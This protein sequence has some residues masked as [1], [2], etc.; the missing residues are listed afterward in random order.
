MKPKLQGLFESLSSVLALTCGLLTPLTSFAANRTWTGGGGADNNWMTAAN[1]QG[2][3]APSPG[4]SLIF[5]GVSMA[6]NSTNRNNFPDGTPF[7]SITINTASGQDFS[8]GG[9]RVVLSNG[10]AESAAGIGIM[11]LAGNV[12][13]NITLGANGPFTAS[14]ALNLRNLIDTHGYQLIVNGTGNTTFSG[15]LINSTLD[16]PD[17]SLVKTNTGTLTFSSAATIPPTNYFDV[18]LGQGTFLMGGLA[19][20]AY[21]QVGEG[22][23]VLDGAARL[24]EL[25]GTLEGSANVSGTGFASELYLYQGGFDTCTPGD[26][27]APGILQCASFVC[28]QSFFAAGAL[29]IKVNGTTPGTGYSQLLVYSNYTL[30][31]VEFGSSESLAVQWDYTPQIGDSFR[32]LDKASDIPYSITTNSFFEGLPPNCI[33]DLTNGS[34]VAVIYDTNGVTLSTVRTSPQVPFPYGKALRVHRADMEQPIGLSLTT[35][36][37]ARRQP[38]E[39]QWCSLH[40]S[41]LPTTAFWT[42]FPFRQ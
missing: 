3:V 13:F 5:N 21:V 33:D 9:N 8:L 40:I 4:D 11:A 42:Q 1:W 22:T 10:I 18:N 34:S 35:G 23:F 39:A 7:G 16:Q 15:T 41:G 2:D 26:N 19:S 38:A 25:D 30:A 29:Q 14:H 12:Y 36:R 31:Q 28:N 24:V 27:G 20:N 37:K 32:V 17:F 6:G